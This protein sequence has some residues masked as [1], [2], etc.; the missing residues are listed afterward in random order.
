[1]LQKGELLRTARALQAGEPP[2]AESSVYGIT[3]F[4][5]NGPDRVD[6]Q[7]RSSCGA[8][9]LAL[10]PPRTVVGIYPCI[11]RRGRSRHLAQQ[12]GECLLQFL[13]LRGVMPP[14]PR[15]LLKLQF[16]MGSWSCCPI[17]LKIVGSSKFG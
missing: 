16:E 1:M 12:P 6:P 11:L 13:W 7:A 4:I 2:F 8:V 3:R 15:H 17:K 10:A 5:G 9:F 14:Y